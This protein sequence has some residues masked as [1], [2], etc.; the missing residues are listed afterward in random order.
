MKFSQKKLSSLE[1][2]EAYEKEEQLKSAI[3]F[4]REY[5]KT[6]KL[7][8]DQIKYLCEEAVRGGCQVCATF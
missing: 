6:T 8:T 2:Q 1:L 5:I 3:V 4:A 7:T